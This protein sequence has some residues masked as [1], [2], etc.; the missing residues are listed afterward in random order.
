MRTWG[1]SCISTETSAAAGLV[2]E[3]P[4]GAHRHGA[5]AQDGRVNFRLHTFPQ[6]DTPMRPRTL[7]QNMAFVELP[8]ATCPCFSTQEALAL[9]AAG[10][11]TTAAALANA[12]F[13]NLV[14]P[15]AC[16]LSG[17]THRQSKI[18]ASMVTEQACDAEFYTTH[19]NP[20]QTSSRLTQVAENAETDGHSGSIKSGGK[21]LQSRLC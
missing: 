8:I 10:T 3:A 1:D 18:T 17:L 13:I 2:L 11:V 15:S 14:W 20:C 6:Q 16:T 19:T 21:P 5:A 7:P 9:A 12:T 4:R